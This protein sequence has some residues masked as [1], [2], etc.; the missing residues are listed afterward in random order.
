M[1]K[2]VRNGQLTWQICTHETLGAGVY[3]ND[4]KS[5]HRKPCVCILY[6][7]I[8][9]RNES[10]FLDS[11]HACNTDDTLQREQKKGHI[12]LTSRYHKLCWGKSFDMEY[13]RVA[14]LIH[15]SHEDRGQTVRDN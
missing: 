14:Y 3:D 15:D 8:S 2:E 7:K 6:A 9:K 1:N 11:N 13:T 4:E 10:Q 12:K 5:A